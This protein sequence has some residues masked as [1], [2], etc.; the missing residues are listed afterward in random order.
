M[1]PR[2]GWNVWRGTIKWSIEDDE[3]VAHTLVIPKS[4][5]VPQVKVHLLSPQHWAQAQTGVD[6]LDGAGTITTATSCTLFWNDKQAQH[7]VPIDVHGNNVATFYLATGFQRF[8]DYCAMTNLD[9]YDSDPL[10]QMEVDAAMISDDEESEEEHVLDSNG[11]EE[12]WIPST[13]EP[14]SP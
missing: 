11:K 13:E 14:H 1:A 4:Y 3:G 9:D 2:S 7:T 6:K 12:E 8:H 5:Y 10:T